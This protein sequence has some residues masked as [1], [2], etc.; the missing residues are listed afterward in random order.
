MASMS[1]FLENKLIDFLLR[2]QALGITGASAA[3]GTGP[4]NVYFA[5]L[6]AAL[7]DAGGGTEVTGGSYARVNMPTTTTNFDNT[8]QANTTAV[9]SGTSGTTRNSVAI[10]FPAP[11]ANWGVATH[12]GVYDAASAG[13]LLLW[14]AL[15]ASKT[16]NNGDPAPAFAINAFTFQIDN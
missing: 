13:N 14:N 7:S 11:T 12:I 6:T 5:L 16:I 3:A 9:S 2:G 1:D 15:T 10:T 4:T 8:Q